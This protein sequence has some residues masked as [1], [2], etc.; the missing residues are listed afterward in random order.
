M[1]QT[2]SFNSYLIKI[3]IIAALFVTLPIVFSIGGNLSTTDSYIRSSLC[4]FSLTIVSVSLLLGRKYTLFYSVVFLIQLTIGLCHYLTFI[5]PQYFSSK[6]APVDSFWG[7]YQ[8]VFSSVDGLIRDR[9]SISLFYFDKESWHV[10][11]SEI[12]RII[13][14][15]FTFLG[16]KWLSYSPLNVFSSLLA[17]T[18]LMVVFNHA[19]PYKL[20]DYKNARRVL[21]YVTAFFPLFLLNDNFLRD[22]FGVA[23]ISIGLVLIS[24]SKTLPNQILSYIL[25]GFSSFIMRSA[26]IVIAGAAIA[27]RDLRVT[28]KG[29]KLV[30]IPLFVVALIILYQFFESYESED[31]VGSYVNNMSFLAFP[32]KVLFALI[33]PFPWTQFSY[34]YAGLTYYSF[35]L[36]Y[37]IMGV[38]QLGFLFAIISKWKHLSFKNADYMTIMGLGMMISGIL[39]KVMHI[40]YIAVG[41]YFMLPWFF[42]FFGRD[43]GKYFSYSLLV[44]ILL[45]IL[46]PLLGIHGLSGMLR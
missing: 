7:E 43:F 36:A 13:S 4:F 21:L 1:R 38:F 15:P 22:T 2:T 45:N 9:Q 11:H 8:A 6:G 17:S 35:Q 23:L 28:K 34:V 3:L 33:G 19:N 41:V 10:T 12:W 25:L 31:Y 39:T 44:L 18:N 29:V 37:Y 42:K 20:G 27:I 24:L 30:L 16:H 40:T 26:Y 14:W 5:D 32:L 46:M